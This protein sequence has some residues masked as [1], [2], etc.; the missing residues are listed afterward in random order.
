MAITQKIYLVTGALPVARRIS[1]RQRALCAGA[2]LWQ[3]EMEGS[4]K[5]GVLLQIFVTGCMQRLLPARFVACGRRSTSGWLG[6]EGPLP[7][8][9]IVRRAAARL[10]FQQIWQGGRIPPGA[11]YP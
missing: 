10:S 2:R 1:I 7:Y 8:V 4:L 6:Q 11:R 9:R 5:I 3:A